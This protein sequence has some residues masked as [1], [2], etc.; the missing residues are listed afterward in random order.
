MNF[1]I[2]SELKLPLLLLIVLAVYFQSIGHPFSRF[3]DPFIVEY[4]GINST[5]SFLD[6]IMPGGGFYYRPIV[7]VSYWLDNLLWGLN[8]SFMHLENIAAHLINVS[9]VFLIASRLPISSK[10]TFLPYASALLFGVHPIN[11][12]SVYWVAGRTDILA[13]LFIFSSI[14]CLIRA[15]QAQSPW[16]AITAY[17]LAIVGM[18]TKETAFMFIPAAILFAFFWPVQQEEERPHYKKWRGQWILVPCV[19]ITMLALALLMVIYVKGNGNNA[20]AVLFEVG[21]HNYFRSLE[22]LGFYVKKIYQPLPLNM[23]I[24]E[25][26]HWYALLGVFS[27]S[28]IVLT[29]RRAGVPVILLIC[30]VFFT[31]P[32]LIIATTSFAWTPFGERY[33]YIPSAFAVIASLEF[34][35]R[36][37]KRLHADRWFVAI[38][39]IIVVTAAVATFQRGTLWGD[40]LKMLEDM[41][42]KSPNFGVILG[43]YGVVLKMA[44]RYHEA[45][46]YFL[47]AS[48]KKNKENTARIINLNLAEM[49]LHKK[50]PDEARTILLRE[51][52]NKSSDDVEL[53]KLLNRYDESLLLETEAPKKRELIVAGIVETNENLFLKTRDPFYLYRSGQLSLSIG[54]KQDAAAFFRKAWEQARP[55]AYYREPARKLFEKLDAE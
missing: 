33:L 27:L 32:A 21:T 16:L 10:I 12:E 47:M 39:S 26:S 29:I 15:I 22:A 49:K 54:N 23:A 34:A 11:S 38:L 44:G 43:E 35:Y 25:V 50:T 42:A 51:I 19:I 36:Y 46:K 41:V 13:G 55:D 48:Q 7:N 4:Y 37:A 9:L 5:L 53:L 20:L 17:F 28:L 24:V 6:V 45:E 40:N 3:D 2:R 8:P 52:G 31:L 30:A 18:L 14:Y 1:I